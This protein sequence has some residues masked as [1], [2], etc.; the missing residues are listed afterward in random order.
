MN[1]I[2]CPKCD[3][4][5]IDLSSMQMRVCGCCHTEYAWKL[6]DGKSVEKVEKVEISKNLD[7][8]Q[9]KDVRY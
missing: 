9:G 4:G 8:H 6:V 7:L 5:L 3:V 1:S 2:K